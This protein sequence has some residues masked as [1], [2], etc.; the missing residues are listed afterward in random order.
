MSVRSTVTTPRRG[1]PKADPVTDATA[2]PTDVRS[3]PADTRATS[4]PHNDR[5]E[6]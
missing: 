5:Q 3:D 4:T 1:R 2:N 6:G